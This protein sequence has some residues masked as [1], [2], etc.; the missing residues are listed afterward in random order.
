MTEKAM[1]IDSGEEPALNI[2]LEIKILRERK[3]ISGKELAEKIGLSQSQMSRLEKGQRRIDAQ[4]LHK[5]A[6][7]LD[8]RPSFFFG[9]QGIPDDLSLG[10]IHRDM[11]RMIRAERR[12][13]HLSADD[14]AKRIAKPR[15]FV[16]AVEGGEADLLNN[17]VVSR[18]CRALKMEPIRFF[19]AQQRTV[20]TLRRQLQR[21]EKAHADRTLGNLDPEAIGLGAGEGTPRRPIPVLGEIGGGY[22]TEFG[23]DGEP[24]AEVDDYVFLPRVEDE[25]TFGVHVSG[26]SMERRESPSFSD[27]DIVVFSGRPEVRSRDFVLVHLE[28]QKTVFRQVFF[29]PPGV[30]LQPL[31]LT[32]PPQVF[33]REEV[34]RMWRLVAH[35]RR[36]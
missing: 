17:E 7:A 14:L 8:V 35:I 12:K 31:N 19:E 16:L 22:P 29:D 34:L 11:G 33:H 27:G 21:L 36:L 10:P 26:D 6:Q 28:A 2:G 24:V 20:Q 1:T 15:S 32:F 30:R 4:I 23:P 3:R 25:Q 13:R 5:I 18:I 9:E